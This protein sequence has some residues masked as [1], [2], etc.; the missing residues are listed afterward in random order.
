[1]SLNTQTFKCFDGMNDFKKDFK[2]SNLK[3]DEILNVI[4]QHEEKLH[5][6]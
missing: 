3:Q 6:S 2:D 4:G 1:M 5:D